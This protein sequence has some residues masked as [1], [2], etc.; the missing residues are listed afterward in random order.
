MAYLSGGYYLALRSERGQYMS[1]ELIPDRILSASGCICDSFPDDWA[2]QWASV[3]DEERLKAAASFGISSDR[4][5]DVI[6]WA[7]DSL[8]KEFGWTSAFYTLKAAK[9][10]RTRFLPDALEIVTFG[11]GL[12]EDDVQDFLAAAKPA[13]TSVGESGVFQCI[14]TGVSIPEG[15][16]FAGFELITTDNGMLGCSWLCNSLET[17]CAAELGIRPNRSGFVRDYA[18]AKLCADFISRPETGAEPGPW[19]PWRVT[20]FAA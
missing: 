3:V 9:Q 17:A 4:L 2:I 12:H 8:S 1:P 6:A 20:I 13:H 5:P 11:L 10:A 18:E 7:T 14:S 16:E 19:L 15:G